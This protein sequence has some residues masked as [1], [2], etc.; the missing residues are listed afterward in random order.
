MTGPAQLRAA[1]VQDLPAVSALL[2]ANA[3]PL[4]GVAAAIDQFIVAEAEGRLV[5]VAGIERCGEGPYA[6]LRSVVVDDAWKGRGVGGAVVARALE[7]AKARGITA[8]Y[9]LTT[10]AER[11]FPRFGFRVTSREA[12]PAAVRATVEFASACP[13]SAVVMVRETAA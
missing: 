8:L 5:A 11:Y 12:A 1:T 4:D 2:T 9:L 10:T 6:L 3:L 7:A 13:A